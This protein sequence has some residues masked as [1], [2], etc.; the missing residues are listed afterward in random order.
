MK[1]LC[2]LKSEM[3][4]YNCKI[5]TNSNLF[6]YLAIHFSSLLKHRKYSEQWNYYKIRELFGMAQSLFAR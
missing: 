2:N 3:C 5:L 1:G 4:L 6:V